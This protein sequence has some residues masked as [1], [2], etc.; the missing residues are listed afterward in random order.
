MKAKAAERFYREKTYAHLTVGDA[1]RI[2]RELQ[3]LTQVELAALSRL[4]QATISG[5][6]NNRV[7]LGVER[8]KK[9][10]LALKVHPAVILFPDW[11]VEERGTW[12]G[13]SNNIEL[14]QRTPT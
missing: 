9:L 13:H 11:K 5:V 2:A 7:S 6:E 14:S 8:A 1:V 4:T 10:A 3:G 12:E